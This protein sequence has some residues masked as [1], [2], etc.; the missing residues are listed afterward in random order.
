[1]TGFGGVGGASEEGDEGVEFGSVA[2]GGVEGVRGEL[3]GVLEDG[4]GV[5]EVGGSVAVEEGYG[6]GY[7][8]QWWGWWWC[9]L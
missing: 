7:R 2:G 1:M 8:C 3:D 9:R 6:V 5:E 4:G